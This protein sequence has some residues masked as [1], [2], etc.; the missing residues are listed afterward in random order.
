[1]KPRDSTFVHV[2]AM[3]QDGS[4]ASRRRGLARPL[5]SSWPTPNTRHVQL[6]STVSGRQPRPKS[7]QYYSRRTAVWRIRRSRIF[8]EKFYK[9]FSRRSPG[10]GRARVILPK[11]CR[12]GEEPGKWQCSMESVAGT[13]GDQAP[14]DQ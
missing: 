2:R 8:P 6:R 13:V 3:G 11:G 4:D 10:A 14:A 1:M 12:D 9:R 5:S 7:Q